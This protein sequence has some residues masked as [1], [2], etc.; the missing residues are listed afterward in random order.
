MHSFR[1]K[2]PSR[3]C[4]E[5]YLRYRSYKKYLVID[6]F[7]RCGYC[8]GSD[9]CYGGYKSFHIDH[10]A[11]SDQF[12]QRETAYTNL[13]YSCPFCN[14]AKSNKWPSNDPDIN[15]VGTTGFLNPVTDDLNVNFERDD[16]GNIVGLTDIARDMIVNLNLNLE[17]H[18]VIW[19]LSKLEFLIQNYEDALN[20]RGLTTRVK[21]KLS[22]IHYNLL[23]VFF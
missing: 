1:E 15:I 23:Q 4:T 17:R 3:T 19:M 5:T 18:S 2:T 9:T 14:N 8:N 7:N 20:K 22:D 21:R 6:F 13:I 10:F 16:M 11:P 12:P